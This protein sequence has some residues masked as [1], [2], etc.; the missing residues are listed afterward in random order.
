[1]NSPPDEDFDIHEYE[2]DDS[3]SETEDNGDMLTSVKERT[4]PTLDKTG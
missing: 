4:D 2:L 3:N 1:V